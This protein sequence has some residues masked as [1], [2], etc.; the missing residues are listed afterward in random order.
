MLIG[1]SIVIPYLP[2]INYSESETFA[3]D[4]FASQN[5]TE[6]RMKI[7]EVPKRS[8]SLE[9]TV[10]NSQELQDLES[11]IS[12]ASRYTCYVP[13]WFSMIFSEDI[14]NSNIINCD[15]SL[16]DFRAD[17]YVLIGANDYAKITALNSTSITINKTVNLISGTKIVPLLYA[18]VDKSNSYSFVTKK[19]GSFI[20]NF[21]ELI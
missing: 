1:N 3:T 12:Y 16:S 8:V 13:L 6:K 9:I 11:L 17:D 15:T 14:I 20:L 21:R 10:K 2:L 19:V 18:T 5:N 7:V 4:I